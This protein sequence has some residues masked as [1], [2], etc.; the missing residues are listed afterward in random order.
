MKDDNDG[1]GGLQELDTT[2]DMDED[3]DLGK[4][5]RK[6][7]AGLPQHINELTDDLA[8]VRA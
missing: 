7:T 5:S 8:F 1:S 6:F 2:R 3:L 4:T